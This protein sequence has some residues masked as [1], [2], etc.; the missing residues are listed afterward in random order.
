[1]RRVEERLEDELRVMREEMLRINNRGNKSPRRFN[2]EL[3]NKISFICAE[4]KE[5]EDKIAKLYESFEKFKENIKE[6]LLGPN[7][8]AKLVLDAIVQENEALKNRI[9]SLEENNS[10]S[11]SLVKKASQDKEDEIFEAI[12]KFDSVSQ[13]LEEDLAAL[14]K[15]TEHNEDRVNG[16][17]LFVEKELKE[18]R[19]S[20]G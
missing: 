2:A 6:E 19:K 17:F 10:T 20:F 14:Q 16:L 13:T 9:T 5:T 18:N 12:R 3:E 15:K 7:K 1:M 8:D 4:K 11:D